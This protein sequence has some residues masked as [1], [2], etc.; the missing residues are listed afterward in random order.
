[1]LKDTSHRS[2]WS[3][4]IQSLD[5]FFAS[6]MLWP[7]RHTKRQAN[8]NHPWAQKNQWQVSLRC[9]ICCFFHWAWWFASLST[10]YPRLKE[11]EG[12][13]VDMDTADVDVI[14]I[15]Y[16]HFHTN[17]LYISWVYPSPHY[18]TNSGKWEWPNRVIFNHAGWVTEILKKY[19]P[20]LWYYT[21]QV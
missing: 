7:K 10:E 4:Q 8:A 13:E 16:N 14:F 17:A 9:W 2:K 15:A 11:R 12:L 1:M 6:L 20:K 21:P 5:H 18:L 3:N 19:K